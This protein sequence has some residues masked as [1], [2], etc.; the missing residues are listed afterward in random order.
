MPFAAYPLHPVACARLIGDLAVFTVETSGPA[1]AEFL[2]EAG[3]DAEW[4][5]GPAAGEVAA[6]EVVMELNSTSSG[7]MY[8]SLRAELTRTLQIRRSGLD[9]YLIE[10]VHEDTWIEGARY[11]LSSDIEG[12]PWTTYRGEDQVWF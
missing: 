2:S 10:M 12:R 6:G 5:R 11:L 9:R 3:L 4:V 1:L 7:P 8:G